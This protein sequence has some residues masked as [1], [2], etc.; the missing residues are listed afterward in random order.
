VLVGSCSGGQTE[1]DTSEIDEYV[2]KYVKPWIWSGFY[3]RL[4]ARELSWAI[5]GRRL[6]DTDLST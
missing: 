5:A 3:S 1:H 6:D 2:A 4:E